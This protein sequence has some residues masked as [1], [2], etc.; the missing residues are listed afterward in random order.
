MSIHPILLIDP[1]TLGKKWLQHRFSNLKVLSSGHPSIPTIES[2]PLLI[3][4]VKTVP[5][6][7]PKIKELYLCTQLENPSFPLTVFERFT[8]VDVAKFDI[9]SF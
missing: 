9:K 2:G 6:E 3:E 1:L 4:R 5:D 7:L 8:V